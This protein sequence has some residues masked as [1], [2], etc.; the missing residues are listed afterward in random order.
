MSAAEDAV[1]AALLAK[2][3]AVFA[4]LWTLAT[5]ETREVGG[6]VAMA[7][8]ASLNDMIDALATRDSA[9]DRHVPEQVQNLLLVTFGILGGVM[10]FSSG[11]A[12]IRPNIPV[13]SMFV[14]MVLLV[15]LILDLH[16]PRR[17]MIEVDQSRMIETVAA[18]S[19]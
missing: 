1:R 14:L 18:M 15:F 5:D 11:I 6:P 7:F 4:Q 8:A 9:I 16:R 19:K 13:Y 2:A 12:Q 3:E 17:G 10:G